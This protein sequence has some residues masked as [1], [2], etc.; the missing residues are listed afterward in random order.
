VLEALV[1]LL[2]LPATAQLGGGLSGGKLGVL[3]ALTVAL[4]LTAGL[5]RRPAAYTVGSALQVAI[6]LSGLLVWP[7]FLLGLAFGAIWV[8]LLRLRAELAAES[9]P[10]RP[11]G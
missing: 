7:M 5:L 10:D 4:V 3:L 9:R 6:L 8:Y 11:A 2:A 1:V